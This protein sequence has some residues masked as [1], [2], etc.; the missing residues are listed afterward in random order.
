MSAYIR[1]LIS[2]YLTPDVSLTAEEMQGFASPSL[3]FIRSQEAYWHASLERLMR[4]RFTALFWL[5]TTL[6]GLYVVYP[7][8]AFWQ[9]WGAVGS[10]GTALVISW[11]ISAEIHTV[12][13]RLLF[14]RMALECLKTYY[15]KDTSDSSETLAPTHAD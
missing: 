2:T 11:F 8:M 9:S 7:S 5:S 1:Y 14:Y 6:G 13:R 4:L 3:E 12:R 10:I 15:P